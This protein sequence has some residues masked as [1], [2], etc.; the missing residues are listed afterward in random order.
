MDPAAKL[1]ADDTT[2]R[3]TSRLHHSVGELRD[4]IESS[5]RRQRLFAA[6]APALSLDMSP[7]QAREALVGQLAQ[8]REEG[9]WPTTQ[10]FI[11][12]PVRNGQRLL[13]YVGRVNPSA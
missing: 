4:G 10:I 13:N 2:G 11:E 9:K 5:R 8:P 6:H 1:G 3:P 12:P 7:V